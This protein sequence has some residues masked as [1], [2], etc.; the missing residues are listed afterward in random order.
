MTGRIVFYAVAGLMTILALMLLA[1]TEM[2][3]VYQAF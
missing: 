1:A 3:F 2:D